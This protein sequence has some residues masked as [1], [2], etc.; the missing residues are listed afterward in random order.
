MSNGGGVGGL[1]NS[2]RQG[3]PTAAAVA[4][5]VGLVGGTIAIVGATDIP[6]LTRGAKVPTVT[7]AIL[8]LIGVTLT[9]V[10]ALFAGA[11]PWLLLGAYVA[12][13]LGLV[14]Y[15]LAASHVTSDPL[16]PK[17]K[18]TSNLVKETTRVEVDVEGL[19]FNERLQVGAS[20]ADRPD[21]RF[22][23]VVIG[24]DTDGMAH[25]DFVVGPQ[26]MRRRLQISAHVLRAEGVPR[27]LDCDDS[28]ADRTCAE[29]ARVIERGI[30]EV[31]GRV[32]G[33]ML[34]VVVQD[35]TR[36]PGLVSIRASYR[37]RELYATRTR[38]DRK[39]LRRSIRLTKEELR[40]SRAICL[41]ASYSVRLPTCDSKRPGVAIVRVHPRQV[42]LAR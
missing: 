18:M 10:S 33:R 7:G 29:A 22:E 20:F 3:F 36:I 40:G 28:E 17:I 8:L 14:A 37:G 11:R 4:G 35:R 16:A 30:P 41:A 23:R 5:L 38:V 21:E 2:V 42:S 15:V 6:D 13:G 1:V 34:G 9:L 39:R 26:S 32:R 19:A 31:R 24:G 25:Y 27:D 12:T